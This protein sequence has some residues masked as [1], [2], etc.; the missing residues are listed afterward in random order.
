MSSLPNMPL[1]Y[2]EGHKVIII[3]ENVLTQITNHT[4]SPEILICCST[5]IEACIIVCV[6]NMD[7]SQ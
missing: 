7:L 2:L 4:K 1:K 6:A 3:G 5:Y